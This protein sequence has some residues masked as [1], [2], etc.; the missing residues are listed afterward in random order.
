MMK[1]VVF[2]SSWRDGGNSLATMLQDHNVS[3]FQRF[4]NE[5]FRRGEV[6]VVITPEEIASLQPDLIIVDL[7]LGGKPDWSRDCLENLNEKGLK[8]VTKV[9]I[10]EEPLLL[11]RKQELC[12]FGVSVF[13]QWSDLEPLRAIIEK[14]VCKA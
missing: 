7:E 5:S 13:L 6:A 2:D 8:G 9:V 3:V 4:S 1:V 14:E 11:K 10:S 12:Y